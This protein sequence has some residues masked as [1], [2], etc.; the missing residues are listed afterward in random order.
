VRNL[1]LGESGD[2]SVT[3]QYKNTAGRWVAAPE[4]PNSKPPSVPSS[5]PRRDCG[6]PDESWRAAMSA[7]CRIGSIG[8]KALLRAA[9]PL[10]SGARCAALRSSRPEGCPIMR[11]QTAIGAL[12]QDLL[13]SSPSLTWVRKTISLPGRSG[14]SRTSRMLNP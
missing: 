12:G 1:E 4:E 6:S 14:A 10:R 9:R 2:A 11:E 8:V 3:A 13:S 5:W 7:D